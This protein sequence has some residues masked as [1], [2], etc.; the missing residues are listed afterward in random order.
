MVS[1]SSLDTVFLPIVGYNNACYRIGM[2]GGFY[3]RSFKNLKE[4]SPIRIGLAF[5][6]QE[7]NFEPESHATP[8]GEQGGQLSAEHTFLRESFSHMNSPLLNLAHVCCELI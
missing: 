4:D 3:D 5:S 8:V 7:V 6:F 1:P 2:G